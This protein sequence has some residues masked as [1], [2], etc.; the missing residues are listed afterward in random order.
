MA[1]RIGVVVMAGRIGVVV[2]VG[3]IRVVGGWD[4]GNRNDRGGGDDGGDVGNGDDGG[5]KVLVMSS[6]SDTS[7]AKHCNQSQGVAIQK[8]SQI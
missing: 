6:K 7:G 3:M 4:G 8:L 1:G 5:G 2:M